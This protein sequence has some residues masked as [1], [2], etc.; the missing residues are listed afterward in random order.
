MPPHPS[1]EAGAPRACNPASASAERRA[2]LATLQ[3]SAFNTAFVI[4]VIAEPGEVLLR[5]IHSLLTSIHSSQGRRLIELALYYPLARHSAAAKQSSSHSSRLVRRGVRGP[6]CLTPPSR[7]RTRRGTSR[8]RRGRAAWQQPPPG[9]GRCRT[10]RRCLH[11]WTRACTG[12]CMWDEGTKWERDRDRGTGGAAACSAPRACPPTHATHAP[13]SPHAHTPARTRPPALA[14]H[15]PPA[16][17]PLR[18]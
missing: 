11:M 9:C 12:R 8:E 4:A 3:A 5:S 18:S 10:R 14:S 6:S 7:Y 13:P 16:R 2:L 1:C 17:S 15:L